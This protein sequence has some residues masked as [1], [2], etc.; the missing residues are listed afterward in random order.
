M[1]Q[2]E[3]GNRRLGMGRGVQTYQKDTRNIQEKRHERIQH[4]DREANP[5]KIR[6]ME[7]SQLGKVHHHQI[8]GAAYGSV[9]VEADDRVHLLAVVGQQHLGHDQTHGLK[10]QSGDLVAHA[11][12]ADADLAD[13]G[14]HDADDDD[15]DFENGGLGWVGDAPEPADGE[16]EDGA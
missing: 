2:Y 9:V 14:D 13:T 7:R 6:H 15:N 5:L 4:Q 8:H 3:L 10:H 16:G 11:D 1:L 12:P